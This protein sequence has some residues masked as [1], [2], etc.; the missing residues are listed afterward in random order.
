MQ[1]KS[2]LVEKTAAMKGLAQVNKLISMAV[3]H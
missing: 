1:D 2:C 3:I